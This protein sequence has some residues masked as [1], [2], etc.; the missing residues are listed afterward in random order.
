[1]SSEATS[2]A[3]GWPEG[4]FDLYGSIRD[5]SF[6]AP[7]DPMPDPN[8]VPSFDELGLLD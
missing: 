8:D 3:K 4:W 2:D 7:D 1:M 6:V 5:E